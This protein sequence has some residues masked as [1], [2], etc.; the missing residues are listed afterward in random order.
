MN[1]SQEIN[2]IYGV[3][4]AGL[5]WRRFL[6]KELASQFFYVFINKKKRMLLWL[7]NFSAH[8]IREELILSSLNIRIIYLPAN[9]M[10]QFQPLDQE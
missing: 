8:M 10:S 5:Y 3:D 7:D 9:S 2:I 6:F 1:T 4:E